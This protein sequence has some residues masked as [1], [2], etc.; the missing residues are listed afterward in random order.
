M[1]MSTFVIV[2]GAW[3]GGWEWSDVATR[4]RARDHQAYTPSLT[5]LGER[6]H[7]S[8]AERVGLATH[9]EDI[10]AALEFERLDDVVLCGASYGGMPVTGAADRLGDR[11]RG[12][13]Y[14]DALVPVDGQCALD[15]LPGPFGAIVRRGLAEHGDHWRVAI[16]DDLVDALIPSGALPDDIRRNYLAR[17]R[18]HPAATF[19]DP[20]TLTSAVE[21]LRRAFVRCTTADFGE[22]AGGDP[23]VPCAARAREQGWPYRELATHHDPQVFVPEQLTV[24]L[25]EL[26]ALL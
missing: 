12:V 26:G 11:V 19:A 9:V 25:E 3:G 18:D 10:V 17:L 22:E 21:G 1:H 8:R 7:L 4:L 5:G 6:S 16:P 14:I 24:L 23:I 2:H 13:I 20:I 15:L